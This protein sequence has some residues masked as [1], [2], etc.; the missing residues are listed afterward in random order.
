VGEER[1]REFRMRCGEAARLCAED[2]FTGQMENRA[3]SKIR[4]V[5]CCPNGLS[6]VHRPNTPI[7][8]GTDP[9]KV[10]RDG[11]SAG[12]TKRAFVRASGPR[13]YI[14]AHACFIYI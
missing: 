14:Y 12:P 7:R 11:P 8:A 3:C 1:V 4:T 6:T 5:S 10:G 2:A 9:L 13:A